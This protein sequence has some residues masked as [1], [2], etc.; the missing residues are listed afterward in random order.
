MALADE[1]ANIAV[2]Y[3]TSQTA[4][5]ELC[6][7]LEASGVEARGF[8]ADLGNDDEV[9]RLF[10]SIFQSFG[11]LDVLVC[12]ASRFFRTPL[13]STKMSE[14]D[15]LLRVN[16]RS[17]FDLTRRAGA[18]MRERGSGSIVTIGDWAGIRPYRNYLPYCVSKAGVIA[19]HQGTG[20]R[21]GALRA[22]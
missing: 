18:H 14:W 6:Q 19:P 8:R 13:A 22:G 1:G 3:H 2:H 12:N 5:E 16:L 9:E 7:L 10:D 11:R 4:A 20:P 15:E 21:A 17:V